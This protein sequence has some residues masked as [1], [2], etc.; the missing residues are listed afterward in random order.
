MAIAQGTLTAVRTIAQQKGLF[1]KFFAQGANSLSQSATALQEL[2]TVFQLAGVTLPK[3]ATLTMDSAQMILSGG[4][5]VSDVEQGAK[6]L[7]CVG[8]ASNAIAGVTQLLSDL[9]L[10]DHQFG[11][12]AGLISNVAL[13]IASGGTNI[14]ADLGAVLS[15]INVVGDLGQD[16]FGNAAAAKANAMKNLS[17]LVHNF[18]STQVNYAAQ[19]AKLYAA[20]NLNEF[21]YIANIALNAPLAFPSYFPNLKTFFPS[22]ATV[23]VT[24]YGNSSGWFS[25]KTDVEKTQFREMF[26]NAAQVQEVLLE[27]FLLIPLQGFTQEAVVNRAASIEAIS[28]LSL[29]LNTGGS[30]APSINF[31]FDVVTT[32]VSLGLTPS[33]LGDDWLFKGFLKNES[34][35]SNW[36]SVLPYKPLTMPWIQKPVESG[37]VI[38]GIPLNNSQYQAQLVASESQANFQA[39]L[40]YLDSIGDIDTL[41]TIPEAVAMLRQWGQIQYDPL[42]GAD[43]TIQN[44]ALDPGAKDISTMS[45]YQADNAFGRD[46]RQNPLFYPYLKANYGVDVSDYWKCLSVL[47]LMQRSNILGSITANFNLTLHLTTMANIQAKFKAAYNFVMVKGLNRV[48]RAN[49]AARLGIPATKLAS[50]KLSTGQLIFYQS[51]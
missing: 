13:A 14:L 50:R 8:D 18:V 26:T 31:N 39:Y 38:N 6:V 48:A 20:G 12:F 34:T 17:T 21:D 47:D 3:S 19:E 36:Q 2:R 11:D 16:F 41:S 24:A 40:Q 30:Q 42:F 51:K 25:S 22:W 44:M 7:Q 49:L 9:G 43:G 35:F 32:L 46:P 10:I 23:T 5:F 1:Q 15:L 37:V 45:W 28:V 27:Q 29:L 4:A 33:I